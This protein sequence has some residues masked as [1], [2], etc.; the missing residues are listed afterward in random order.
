M[1]KEKR[2]WDWFCSNS[3]VYSEINNLKDESKIDE[4]LDD[5]LS[6]L[7]H[8]SEGLYFQI[9]GNEKVNELIISAEG[10]RKYFA[11]VEQLASSAPKINNWQIIA[12]KP[13]QGI[14]FITKYKN[15]VLNPKEIWFL[16]LYNEKDTS[17]LGLRLH[18]PNIDQGDNK[19]YIN[20][21]YE[22]LDTIL[23]E[24]ACSLDID[25]IEVDKLPEYP[26]KEDLIELI[27]LPEY[28]DWRKSKR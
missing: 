11:A 23:G 20:G 7:H 3:Q 13:A 5:L 18:I 19:E 16:P 9:G 2:F 12:F 22:V 17:Q 8:Y 24:K 21:M 27:E 14:D 4:L 25:Y 1:S 6:H 15:V 10:N 26:E 28:I